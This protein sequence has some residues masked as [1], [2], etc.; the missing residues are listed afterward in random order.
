MDVLRTLPRHLDTKEMSD[1]A[2]QTSG[3]NV[4]V[5]AAAAAAFQISSNFLHAVSIFFPSNMRVQQIRERNRYAIRCNN[6]NF[7]R[8]IKLRI[9]KQ[10][11]SCLCR[12]K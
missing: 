11:S 3:L 12:D 6:N 5:P 9:I 7:E 4:A 8:S 2:I 10:L 1:D